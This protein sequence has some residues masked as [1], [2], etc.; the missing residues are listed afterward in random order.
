MCF[1]R[2]VK[3]KRGK[4][5]RNKPVRGK[6]TDG[7]GS[8]FVVVIPSRVTGQRDNINVCGLGFRERLYRKNVEAL[9]NRRTGSN[10]GIGSHLGRKK[11]LKHHLES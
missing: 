2:H 5:G 10:V 4:R 1:C 7:S 11:W 6:T 9:V 8:D 3:E